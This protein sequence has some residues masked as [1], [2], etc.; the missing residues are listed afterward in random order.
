M[1]FDTVLGFG[2]KFS[3]LSTEFSTFYPKSGQF[4][5][6]LNYTPLAIKNQPFENILKNEKRKIFT[7]FFVAYPQKKSPQI[8]GSFKNINM[9]WGFSGGGLHFGRWQKVEFFNF[10]LEN[11]KSL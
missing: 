4:T 1:D 11:N 3:T 8:G 7:V 9:L 6:L 2:E 10:F 5:T